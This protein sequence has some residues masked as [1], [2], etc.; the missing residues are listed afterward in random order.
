MK[1]SKLE[2]FEHQKTRL[3]VKAHKTIYELK[4]KRIFPDH[5]ISHITF[6]STGNAGDTTLSTCVRDLFNAQLDSVSW[7]LIKIT[8]AVNE[9][10]IEKLNS[11]SAVIIG[12][13]GAFL[14][15]TNPNNV[16]GWEWACGQDQY[17]K[18]L[19]PI[20]VFAVGYNYFTGQERTELFEKNINSL[21]ARS[22]F[23][24]LRNSGSVREI[25][26]FLDESLQS[27]VVYQPCPTMITRKLYP[28][29]K[30]KEITHQVAFNVALDRAHMRMGENAETILNEIAKAMLRLTL[31][32]YTVHFIT[33]CDAEISFIEYL[34][35]FNVDFKFHSAAAWG[36]EKLINFYNDMD[37]VIGM[38]GHGIWVPFGVNCHI[39]SLGNQNKTKWFLEDINALDWYIN[40]NEQAENLCELIIDKF[41]E[42]HEDKRK[43][44]TERLLDAQNSLYSITKR[45]MSRIENILK[46]R[47]ENVRGGGTGIV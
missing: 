8:R 34:R 22:A 24:G 12:G 33:H 31:M 37:V 47:S 28:K 32:G 4:Y 17:E 9:R 38:R 39:I 7:N 15:D 18:I 40:I 25:R 21:V 16:S 6:Y 43:Q 45:N 1:K 2:I 29:I 13:H 14:P 10:Y 11:S 26:S 30:K 23:F 46:K 41:I 35:R 27:K 3:L 44:T 42:I 19:V 5:R 20:I 36:A